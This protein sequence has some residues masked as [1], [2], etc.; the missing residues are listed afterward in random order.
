MSIKERKNKRI[1]ITRTYSSYRFHQKRAAASKVT[2][3]YT[4]Q[5]LRRWVNECLGKP[6]WYCGTPITE[7]NYSC[8]HSQPISRGGKHNEEN[9]FIICSRC[10]E[11]K[12]P[13]TSTEFDQLK[14]L[15]KT[16]EPVAAR[17]L[18]ARLRAGARFVKGN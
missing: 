2:L 10:N 9:L 17:N 3:N 8:D 14:E 12:G 5:D 7:K 6:C 11:T 13:L 15:T 16:W 1:F 18:L 4:L